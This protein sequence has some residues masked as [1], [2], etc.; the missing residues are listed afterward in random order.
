[1]R[2]SL[3]WL[4][5]YVDLRLPPE[6]LAERLTAA[7]LA[8]DAIERT[9]GDWGDEV[10]VGHVQAVDPHPNADRLRLVSVDV[11]DGERHRVVCG[12]PNV[13]AGQKIAFGVVGTRFRDGHSGKQGVLKLN[14]DEQYP[15]AAYC[16]EIESVRAETAVC[17]A[18]GTDCKSAVHLDV[19]RR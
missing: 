17:E 16:D 13:A 15:L 7:G 19:G 5:E 12:A 14:P 10:R 9:G 8:V 11:G 2:V 6:E 1:M 3:K 4:S 18:S